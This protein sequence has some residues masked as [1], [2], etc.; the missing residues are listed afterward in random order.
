M[1]KREKR[2]PVYLPLK[3]LKKPCIGLINEDGFI[4]YY[5]STKSLLSSGGAPEKLSIEISLSQGGPETDLASICG[6]P[7]ATFG[8]AFGDWCRNCENL[9]FI[10]TPRENPEFKGF[11][12]PPGIF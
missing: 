11:R 12:E 5:N 3:K 4:I 10:N 8:P 1:N 6:A 9:V 7:G 2:M